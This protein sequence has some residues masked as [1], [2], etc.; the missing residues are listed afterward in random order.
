MKVREPVKAIWLWNKQN[1]Y[2]QPRT[3]DRTLI[4]KPYKKAPR[5]NSGV[6]NRSTFFCF[7]EPIQHGGLLS[8]L[9]M[10]PMD[11]EQPR[12]YSFK[13][14]DTIRYMFA[15]TF[16]GYFTMSITFLLIIKKTS[17]L[18]L[19]FFRKVSLSLQTSDT[20]HKEYWWSIDWW[21]TH[22]FCWRWN[23]RR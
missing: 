11:G 17:L 16:K 7:L 9:F 20:C 19:F 1:L 14:N 6:I 21:N 4:T 15:I 10:E 22:V 8:Y 18:S 2:S 3:H 12:F 23:S 5:V 13:T